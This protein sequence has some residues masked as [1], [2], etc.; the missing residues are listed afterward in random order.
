MFNLYFL[1][2][3]LYYDHL[4]Y[5]FCNWFGETLP[6]LVTSHPFSASEE[7]S[8]AACDAD[9]GQLELVRLYNDM[10]KV[11]ENVQELVQTSL[12]NETA[13]AD[14]RENLLPLETLCGDVNRILTLPPET[15]GKEARQNHP[16]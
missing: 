12:T 5:T 4:V 8:V 6:V 9:P 14:L 15:T 2:T 11:M 3:A 1:G 13:G 16:N 10:C 7:I